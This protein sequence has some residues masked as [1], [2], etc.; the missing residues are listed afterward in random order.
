MAFVSFVV[1]LFYWI[2]LVSPILILFV[3]VV[4]IFGSLFGAFAGFFLIE[5]IK[6]MGA[7]FHKLKKML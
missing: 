6:K 1:A 7:F 5:P 3:I 2:K 4:G